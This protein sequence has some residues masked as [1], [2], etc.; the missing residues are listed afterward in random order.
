MIYT[1]NSYDYE[2]SGHSLGS[3]VIELVLSSP[4]EAALD[5]PVCPQSFDDVG[6]VLWKDALLLCCC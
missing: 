3:G 4:R 1:R 2:L 6:Q 5:A